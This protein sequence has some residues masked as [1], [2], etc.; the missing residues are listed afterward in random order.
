MFVCGY[1]SVGVT[2]CAGGGQRTTYGSQ[3]F[4]ATMWVLGTKLNIAWE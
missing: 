4:P 1:V 2:W 3:F